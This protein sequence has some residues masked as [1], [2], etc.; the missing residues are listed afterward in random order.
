MQV[1]YLVGNTRPIDR[2]TWTGPQGVPRLRE[3]EEHPK[4]TNVE[5]SLVTSFHENLSF[6]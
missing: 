2:W 5:L 1:A 6:R 4:S 3:R